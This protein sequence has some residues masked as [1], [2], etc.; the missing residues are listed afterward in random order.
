MQSRAALQAGLM[1]STIA[2][3]TWIRMKRQLR[4]WVAVNIR[5]LVLPA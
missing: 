4:A 2:G 3:T 1:G 5:M